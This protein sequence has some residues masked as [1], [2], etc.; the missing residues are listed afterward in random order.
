MIVFSKKLIFVGTGPLGGKNYFSWW[1]ILSKHFRF[2]VG[3]N[4]KGVGYN[5]VVIGGYGD[6]SKE[7]YWGVR[8]Y[9]SSEVVSTFKVEELSIG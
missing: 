1:F 8:T 4:G 2:Q 5:W 3:G 7:I 6:F 9:F